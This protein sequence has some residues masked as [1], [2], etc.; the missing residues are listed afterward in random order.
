MPPRRRRIEQGAPLIGVRTAA[1]PAGMGLGLAIVR[2]CIKA[3]GGEVRFHNRPEG[4]F[5]VEL[6]LPVLR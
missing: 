6:S 4:G 3:C 1:R 2:A 5:E